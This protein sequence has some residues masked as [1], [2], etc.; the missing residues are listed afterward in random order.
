[1]SAA[2]T[3]SAT[4]GKPYALVV[5]NM[6]G[7]EDLETV[8]PFLRNL[9]ADPYI[10][11][12]PWPLSLLQ[13]TFAELISKRRAPKVAEGYRLIGGGSPL[14]CWSEL[15]AIKAARVASAAGVVC[16]PFVA[17]R[18]WKPFADEAVAEI[19]ALRDA[20][21]LS[22]IVVLSLYPQ[23]SRAT[24]E[25]SLIDFREALARGGLAGV[26]RIEIDRFP[27]LPGYLDA[28]A[29][30]IVRALPEKAPYP[31]VLFSA[32]GLPES[33]V[34]KGDPYRDEIEA[35]YRGI[36]ARLPEGP[37]YGLAFQSKVGPAA[38]LKPYTDATVEALARRGVKDLLMV[39]LA[40]VSDHIETTY[41][42][43]VLYGDLA[44]A[45]GMNF[46]RVLALN[47]D[48]VFSAA[49]GG[50]VAEKV[51]QASTR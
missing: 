27:T 40:F 22:G 23:F 3:A 21:G 19:K 38:W 13:G 50:L 14:R 31:Y 33:Y 7:P 32:H 1:M 36:L 28:T 30:S 12:L 41:E 10:V 9:L 4:D 18:Y 35:T 47:G 5:L 44:R 25:T 17:M 8:R 24:T 43:D 49:L 42:M 39:P 45:R 2:A 37:E 46:S 20:E 11:S 29:A 16:R 34:K 26:P 15:Q 51:R 6:G 48:D